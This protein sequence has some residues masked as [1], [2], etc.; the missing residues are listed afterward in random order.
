MGPLSRF[1]TWQLVGWL[2]VVCLGAHNGLAAQQAASEPAAGRRKAPTVWETAGKFRS[3]LGTAALDRPSERR[4]SAT[5]VALAG[6]EGQSAS[7]APD[8]VSRGRYILA[9]E[10]R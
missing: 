1:V 8:T 4:V 10:H 6:M 3:E 5:S 7:G 9:R 2:P